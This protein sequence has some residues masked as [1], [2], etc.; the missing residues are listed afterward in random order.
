GWAHGASFSVALP[1]TVSESAVMRPIL[2]PLVFSG[3]SREAIEFFRPQLEGWGIIPVVGGSF[4]E[5]LTE[6]DAPFEEG[7][8]VGVQLLR[9]DMSAAAI[10]TLTLKE[11]GK[12]LAL[13][14]PFMLSGAVDFPMTTA[15]IHT[16]IP[17]LIVS[18]KMG[19][20]LKPVG[21]LTQDRTTGVA[22]ILG[23]SSEMVPLTLRIQR[24]GEDSATTANFEI[25]RS[26]QLLP[27]LAGMALGDSFRQAGSQSGEF[28]AKVHYEIELDG[29][30]T[31]CNDD[32][33]SGLRGFPSLASLGLF[34]D[35][36]S[37][38]SNQF[39]E[40]SIRGVSM[41]VE[42]QEA[43]ESAHITGVRIRKDT[44]RPGEEIELK[45][46]MKP[47]MKDYIERQFAL[48][49]P[50]HF[51][52]GKAFVHISAA[53]Q[54][55]AFEAIRAPFRFQ[56]TSIE[57]L[58]KLVDEDYPRNRVD[59]RLLV[60]DPGIVVNGQ[61]MPA[62]PSSVFSVISR[63]VGREPIGITKASVLLEKQIHL[64]FEVNGA[65]LIPITIDRRAL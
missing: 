26:R 62:L 38:L 46:T 4:S 42:L 31:I 19:S 21:T 39:A 54:T 22:G 41:N 1:A 10:G 44:L 35:L 33:L 52:E 27:P 25:V 51:P 6:T 36:N 11:D 53:A 9:G 30:P 59:I 40:L 61:E 32:F 65:I 12:V 16:V 48:R 34:R 47:Y 23:G 64:D 8:A 20:P 15:Y 63:T 29:F 49:I 2:T 18:S 24:K 37:L 55:A 45:I 14:H 7:A 56:P 57:K 60:A 13:G 5:H 43:V 58:V 50:E 28:T 17:S 3:F